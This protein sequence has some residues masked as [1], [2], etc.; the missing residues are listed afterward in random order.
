MPA[1][2]CIA[3]D[4]TSDTSDVGNLGSGGTGAQLKGTASIAS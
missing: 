3:K 1:E 2:S 4:A